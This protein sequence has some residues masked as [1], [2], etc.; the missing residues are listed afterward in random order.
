MVNDVGRNILLLALI[1]SILM[2]VVWFYCKWKLE[3]SESELKEFQEY[4]L[5]TDKKD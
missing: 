5:G 2:I 1:I 4:D 3:P